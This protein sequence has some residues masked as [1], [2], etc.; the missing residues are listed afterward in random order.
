[1]RSI[2]LIAHNIRSSYNVGSLLR[3]ADGLGIKKVY[4]TGNTPYP[5]KLND[6]RLPHAAAKQHKDISK[7]ALGAETTIDWQHVTDVVEVIQ[8]LTDDGYAICA[9]E[10]TAESIPINKY[11]PPKRCALILGN[12]LSGVPKEL[13]SL[14]QVSLEIPMYGKKESFNVAVAAAIALYQLSFY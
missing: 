12:E 9:L 7:T 3:T 11:K 8:H 6:G 4:L 1:M 14:S 10:L 13:L 5:L 2:V